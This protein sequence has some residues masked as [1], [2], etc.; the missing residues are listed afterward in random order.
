MKMKWN[1]PSRNMNL[2]SKA[3][4]GRHRTLKDHWRDEIGNDSVPFGLGFASGAGDHTKTGTKRTKDNA[5]VFEITIARDL[6]ALAEHYQFNWPTEQSDTNDWGMPKGPRGKGQER[7]FRGLVHM[8]GDADYKFQPKLN[9]LLGDVGQVIGRK[10]KRGN[11]SWRMLKGDDPTN[12]GI[13][14]VKLSHPLGGPSYQKLEFF[15]RK[16]LKGTDYNLKIPKSFYH[17]M[18]Y[19]A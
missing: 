11:D 10:Y 4:L 8:Q 14:L 6:I 5:Y 15:Y 7:A 12:T 1:L 19:F 17:W 2:N 3:L 18:M 9:Q 13:V 16:E